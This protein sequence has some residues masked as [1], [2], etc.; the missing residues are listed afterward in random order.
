MPCLSMNTIKGL[1]KV[2]KIDIQSSLPFMAL[3]NDVS[4]G[5]EV[6]YAASTFS[7]TGFSSLV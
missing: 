4:Q 3:F 1:P 2:Y 5:K 6:F 7:K